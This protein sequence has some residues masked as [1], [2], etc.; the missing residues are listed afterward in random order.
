MTRRPSRWTAV[1]AV[2][3]AAVLGGCGAD[4]APAPES[5]SSEPVTTEAAPTEPGQTRPT[6]EPTPDASEGPA[7]GLVYYAGHRARTGELLLFAERVPGTATTSLTD[8]VRA[9]TTGD[10]HDPDYTS[11]WPAITVGRARLLWD[12]DEGFY[13]VRLAAERATGRPRGMSMREAHLAIQ[14]VVWTLQSI[15]GVEAPVAFYVGDAT[16]PVTDLL[17][18]PAT[19]P[20]DAYLAADHAGVLSA[21]NI[22]TVDTAADGTVE[23]SGLAESFEATVG[24]QVLRPTGE[25]V[26][27]D[28]TQAEQCCGRL[29]P[30]SYALDTSDWPAGAYTITAL[31]DDPVGIA[32]GSDGPAR[33]TKTITVR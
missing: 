25:V 14:Q 1:L 9:V 27:D 6:R 8:A 16:E 11:L 21:V 3:T 19:G 28:S 5:T 13:A 29:F 15:G 24:V 31:T 17:G 20:D 7:P 2:A 33:D 22:L 10:P 4:P 18:V 30:W 26:T 12:G 32:Q 23:V